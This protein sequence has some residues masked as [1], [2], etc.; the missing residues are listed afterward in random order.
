MFILA[1]ENIPYVKQAFSE[2][3][4]VHTISGRD[5]TPE[6]L[7]NVDVLLVRSITKV[8]ED[9]LKD[10]RVKFVGTA[11]IGF[12]HVDVD[13]L[14]RKGIKF[15]SAPGSNA[16]SVAEYVVAGLLY[17]EKFFGYSLKHR[18]IGILGVGNVGT[19]VFKKV[20]C[21][22]MIPVLY[23]PP[24]AE[25]IDKPLFSSLNEIYDCDIITLHV[26]LEKGGK[27]PTYHM[28]NSD[29][30]SRL[31]RKV[32]FINT[33]RG[34]VVDTNSLIDAIKSNI[35]NYSI[36]DVWENEPNI[37]LELLKLTNIATPHIA[38]YSFDGKVNGT[39]QLYCALCEHLGKLPTWNYKTCLPN[40]EVDLIEVKQDE[41]QWLHNIVHKVYPIYEDDRKLREIYAKPES[42]QGKF[43]D[44]LR[45]NYP[46]RREFHNT[47]VRLSV[48]D[49]QYEKTNILEGL[50]FT[51][52][53]N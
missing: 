16:N 2:F 28:I 38:G 25:K 5:I 14:L 6:K 13:F 7:K 39:Y 22:G 43:F 11:T 31:R 52:V 23:D 44:S 37:N 12:D 47:T 26:P 4:E 34:A 41:P 30:F 32:V 36:I 20:V 33:S 17:L 19:R 51:V 40:P 27:Y 53:R 21:L 29:F 42:E 10:S 15:A 45:K 8:N 1:D 46:I 3:G 35:V 48:E 49:T 9:L 18:K 50:G 24:L